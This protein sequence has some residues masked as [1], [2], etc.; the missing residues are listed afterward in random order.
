MGVPCHGVWYPRCGQRAPR[1][2][3]VVKVWNMK[4]FA[5]RPENNWAEVLV[6]KQPGIVTERYRVNI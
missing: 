1:V 2:W 3:C 6:N 4:S 5:G